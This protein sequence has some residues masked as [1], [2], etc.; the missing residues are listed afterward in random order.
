MAACTRKTKGRGKN[1]TEF[2]DVAICKAWCFVSTDAAT[3]NA[4]KADTFW[5][6]IANVFNEDRSDQKTIKSIQC[7]WQTIRKGVSK[8][9]GYYAQITNLN[10]SGSNEDV[11]IE[12]AKAL[13]LND[14]KSEFSYLQCW[15]ILKE[16]PKWQ[17]H[18]ALKRSSGE[19]S[20]T[21]IDASETIR[22]MGCKSAKEKRK[23]STSIHVM[24]EMT[25]S[26]ETHYVSMF[27]KMEEQEKLQQESLSIQKAALEIEMQKNSREQYQ[28]EL[29]ILC[30]NTDGLS[31]DALKYIQVKRDRIMA[32]LNEE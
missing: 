32:V 4:Q 3:G 17:N 8:F 2:D 23:E 24:E 10:E 7:R 11:V 14:M 31:D 5:E 1:F 28:Y 16:Q 26:R 20:S 21:D 22:P 12:K 6:K 15:N 29:E 30:K 18:V 27:K 19:S 25:K 9:S 13:Y